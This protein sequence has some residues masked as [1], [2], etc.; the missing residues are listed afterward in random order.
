MKKLP[1]EY[2]EY[3]GEKGRGGKR[4][5]R[6]GREEEEGREEKEGGGVAQYPLSRHEI[7]RFRTQNRSKALFKT[8]LL[9]VFGG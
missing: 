4:G 8:L 6:R 7:F 9:T 3:E 5:E 2:R 1:Y